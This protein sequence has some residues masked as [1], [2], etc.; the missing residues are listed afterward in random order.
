MEGVYAEFG[1]HEASTFRMALR[2]LGKSGPARLS[3]FFAFDSF[4][5]MPEPQ[6]IDRGKLWRKGMNRTSVQEFRSLIKRDLYRVEIVEGF[7]EESLPK[8]SWTENRDVVCAYLDCDFYSSTSACLTFLSDKLAHGA[9]LAFDDWNLY[10]G[11][12]LRGQK[13]A[14]T[15]FVTGNP[16]LVF[17]EFVDIGTLGKSFIVLHKS[18][19]GEAVL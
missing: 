5:G 15:E 12:P 8:F 17:E 3:K 11:D 6:G 19:L 9:L 4:Q 16:N 10:F 1:V 18:L 2:T 14:F 13:R 7:F